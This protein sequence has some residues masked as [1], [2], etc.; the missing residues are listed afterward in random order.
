MKHLSLFILLLCPFLSLPAQHGPNSP[1]TGVN[2]ATTGQ[3]AWTNPGNITASD[4][5]YATVSGS[6]TTNYLFATGFGF[7]IAG[8]ANVDGIQVEIEK[9]ESSP[10]SVSLLDNWSNGLSKTIS[11]GTNRC[12]VVVAAMENGNA[13]RDITAM[14]YGGRAMT[15][16]L[17]ITTGDASGFS[18]TLE[19]WLLM[20][21]DISLA[22]GN[23]IVPTFA[24]AALTENIE[25]YTSAVFQ[26]V[27]Q[28]TP[29]SS[30]QSSSF[31]G[32]TNPHQLGAA[33]STLAGSMAVSGVICGNNT[34]PASSIGGTNTYTIN[35]SFVEGT[36][37]YAANASFSTSGFSLQTATKACATAGTEQPAF[38]FNG[39][40]NRAA[41][42]GFT[43]QR[44]RATDYSVYLL[45][46]GAVT[47]S[48]LAQPATSWPVSESYVSYGGPAALWGTNLTIADINSAGFGAALSATKSNGDIR[49]DH[50]RISVYTTST[51]PI[52]LF[53]FTAAPSGNDVQVSWVTATETNNDYFIVERAGG[54][55]VFANI[56]R[57]E[58]SGN[59][60]MLISYSF[61]DA[62]PLQG[63]SY[64]RLKQVDYDGSA[65]YSSIAAVTFTSHAKASVYPN[66]SAGGVFTFVQEDASAENEVAVFSANMMLVKKV[67]VAPGEKAIISLSDQPDGIYFLV[68][69]E[70]GER[71]VSK[72]EKISREQ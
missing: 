54:D 42:F 47:G 30:S 15:Q 35:S 1:A 64:Y 60:S 27:D 70:G 6:G 3:N 48:S 24:A 71:K 23:T 21:N 66:P 40:V 53:E 57:I 63:A 9:Y 58:G 5:A 33:F 44:A 51:L 45:N 50:F 38:T 67:M 14:T 34:S 37:V 72:V 55:G 46:G 26:Y 28:F 41:M 25:F 20:E 11:A 4:N 8:P 65:S 17:E 69:T 22:S 16:A 62:Q 49:V 68:Y 52:E 32:A 12:L 2:N 29:V 18:A 19:V 43:L 59:S 39:S 36:D 31:A 61:T 56:G 13:P 7:N 10:S